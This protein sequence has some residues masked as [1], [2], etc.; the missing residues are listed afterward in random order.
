MTVREPGGM[1]A[2]VGTPSVAT[3]MAAIKEVESGGDYQAIKHY[4]GGKTGRGAYQI[5]G[6]NWDNWTRGAGIPGADWRSR[7]AQDRV[8]AFAISRMLAR[9]GNPDLVSLAWYAGSMI[10]DEVARARIP[11]D[12]MP[13]KDSL[14]YV[15]KVRG[16]LNK[17]PYIPDDDLPEMS[18]QGSHWLMPV[19]GENSWSRGS[20]LYQRT[21][22]QVAAGKTPVHQGIDIYA[23]KGTPIVSPVGGQVVGAGYSNAGGY[24]A[25]V[26]GDDGI[27]YYFAHM[28][29]KALVSSGQRVGQGF[30]IGFVGASGNARG[31]QP[32]LHFTM[33]NSSDRGLLNPSSWLDG[34]GTASG[35][36]RTYDPAGAEIETPSGSLGWMESFITNSS[37]AVT[38]GQ[39]RVDYRTLGTEELERERDASE[40]TLQGDPWSRSDA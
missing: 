5:T 16:T 30:H 36:L 29:Q 21:D 27:D 39:D 12:D 17:T 34:G 4:G 28:D 1:A 37:A 8:A 3:I 31:T 13:F 23:A 2:P 22:A 9:Y 20:F 32:H 35:A 24:W 7:S 26:K 19:A 15:T 25:K 33:H 38:G 6:K 10:A 40:I 18:T 11:V 14:A